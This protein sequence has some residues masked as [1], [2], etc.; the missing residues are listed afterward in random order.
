MNKSKSRVPAVAVRVPQARAEASEALRLLGERTRQLARIQADMNDA[1]AR[2]KEEAETHA[3]PIR[4]EA[5]AILEGLKVWCEANRETIC[6]RGTKTADLGTGTVSWRLRPPSVSVRGAD[7]VIEACR[8]L[9]LHRFLREK[10]EVNKEAMREEPEVA[11]LIAGVTVGS[12]GE[13]FVAEPFE[14]E[15]EG[16]A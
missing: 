5:E 14:A 16:A 7:S 6:G 8:R 12:A 3:A 11:R 15:L 13:D 1:L 10:V 9:G 4:A 2:I